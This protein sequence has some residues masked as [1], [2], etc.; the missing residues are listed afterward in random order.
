MDVNI[1]GMN[2]GLV[3]LSQR[4][5]TPASTLCAG[6][7]A[8]EIQETLRI[9]RALADGVNPETGDFMVADAV[10][11]Y[12]PVVRALHQAVG[13]LEIMEERQ[14][15]RKASPA[16]AGKSWSAAEDQQVCEE[17]RRGIDFHQIAKTHNRSIGSIIARLVKLRKIGPDAPLDLFGPKMA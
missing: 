3:Q 6:R 2:T 11:Q 12:P 15:N 17:L 7:Y 1:S 9:M 5:R 16:K 8:M 10:Y 14:R 4:N 13:A